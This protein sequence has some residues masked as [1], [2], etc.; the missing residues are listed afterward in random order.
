MFRLI[1]SIIFIAT[2]V[3]VFLTW[4]QPVLGEIKV[5]NNQIN[6]FNNALSKSKELQSVRDD[7]VKKY[8]A[9]SQ[10]N[11][12]K[13]NKLVPSSV[14]SV[15]LIIEM[16]DVVKRHGL[17]LRDIS[18]KEMTEDSKASFGKK[19]NPYEVVS[20]NISA[21]GSY[22]T[23]LSFIDDLEKSLRLVEIKE[24]SFTSSG[25]NLFEIKIGA[26]TFWKNDKNI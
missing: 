17:V 25:T 19:K 2:A 1:I 12:N 21:A 18:A 3:V 10:E 15:R 13:I 9:V 26:I 24:L 16:D 23:L 11:L 14:D 4:T 20:I 7:L 6:V 5:L 8:N 22:E